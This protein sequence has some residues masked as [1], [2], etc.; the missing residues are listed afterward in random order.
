[1]TEV[2]TAGGGVPDLYRPP[3]T[4]AIDSSDIRLPKLKVG[5]WSTPQVQEGL[6]KPGDLFTHLT[7]EDATVLREAKAK[8]GVEEPLEFYVLAVR[9]GWSL[10]RPGE[11]LKS[12]AFDDPNRDPDA[13]KTFTYSIAIPEFDEELPYDFLLSKTSMSSANLINLLLKK[14]E[15]HSAAH[16]LAF[17][18]RTK[19]RENDNGKWFVSAVTPAPATQN[20]AEKKAR[21]ASIE[22]ASTLALLAAAAPQPAA[23]PAIDEAAEP[24]I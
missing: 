5:H 6:A 16:E 13:W 7:K 18:L 19:Y 15:Q 11:D 4:A 14:H 9:K 20:A 24:S 12:W 21:D 3:V 17:H 2:A 1:M 8:V 23:R 10:S 22:V